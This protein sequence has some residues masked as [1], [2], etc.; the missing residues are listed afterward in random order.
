MTPKI[1]PENTQIQK[2]LEWPQQITQKWTLNDHKK[3]KNDSN[4][5]P[6]ND[7]TK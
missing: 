2:S 1:P 5:D 4:Q 7:P 6:K 3:P